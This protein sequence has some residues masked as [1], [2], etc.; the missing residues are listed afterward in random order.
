[1]NHIVDYDYNGSSENLVDIQKLLVL[2][3]DN[4]TLYA[5]YND[6]SNDYVIDAFTIYILLL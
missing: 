4:S 5:Y 3:N 1:M 2:K 6:L